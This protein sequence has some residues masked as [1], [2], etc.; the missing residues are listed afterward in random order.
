MNR[1]KGQVALVAIATSS[2]HYGMFMTL[3]SRFPEPPSVEAAGFGKAVPCTTFFAPWRLEVPVSRLL[4]PQPLPE[5]RKT[6]IFEGYS[7]KSQ[8]GSLKMSIFT[9]STSRPTNPKNSFIPSPAN[10]STT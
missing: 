10:D 9:L 4:N 5:D 2:A 1:V 6:H 8:R 7:R 3:L